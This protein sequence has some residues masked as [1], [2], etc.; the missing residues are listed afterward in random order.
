MK[1]FSLIA[2]LFLSLAAVTLPDRAAAQDAAWIQI[3]AHPDLR[4]ARERAR[5]YA[6]SLERI[7]AFRMRSGWYAIAIGP[8]A[9]PVARQELLLLRRAGQ[10]PGDSFVADGRQFRRQFWPI[11]AEAGTSAAEQAADA[12]AGS[13]LQPGTEVAVAEPQPADE[14]P[15]Q[16]RRGE[17][18]LSREE[19]QEIQTALQWFGF[20]TSSID[21]AFGP[22]TRRAMADW[23][24]A[25]GFEATGILTTAQ[26]GA[27]VENYRAILAKLGMADYTEPEAGITI[28][29]PMNLVA[30]DHY[31]PPF[32]HFRATTDDQVRV[33]LISQSGTRATLH[34]LYDIMQTL[35]IVPLEGHRERNPNSFVLTGRNATL[36]SYTYARLDRGHVKGFTLIWPPEQDATMQKVAAIMRDS[37]RT[38]PDQVLRDDMG[39]TEEQSIDLMAGLE[40]RRPAVSRSGFYIDAAG[41]VLTTSDAVGQCTRLTIDSETEAEVVLTDGELGIAVLRPSETLAPMSYAA[42]SEAPPR[43]RSEIAVAGYSYDGRLGAPTLTYGELADLRGL[44]GETTQRRLAVKALPGDTGGPVLDSGG[45]VVGL[46]MPRDETGSKRLPDDVYFAAAAEP[47]TQLLRENG[48]GIELT[49]QPARMAP[50]DLTRLAGNITVLVSCWN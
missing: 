29:L 42:F 8:M 1:S 9:A 24:A 22:G 32:A 11:D 35:E 47:L 30:F 19:R 31:D 18:N 39:A 15:A 40:I 44:G 17:R 14:T 43:L 21:G 46:L 10:I 6:R 38:D 50:E 2:A 36:A 25:E 12:G 33:I 4:T 7:H 20:Y 5:I 41:S 27:L 16:A 28:S 34:G 3:E 26:R 23:Q 13:D 45:S 37:L 49:S 48:F